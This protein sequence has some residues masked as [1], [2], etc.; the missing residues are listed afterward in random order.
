MWKVALCPR[1]SHDLLV[2]HDTDPS[3][4]AQCPSCNVLFQVCDAISREL[5]EVRLVDPVPGAPV[6]APTPPEPP[7][8][9]GATPRPLG[10]LPFS[11]ELTIGEFA[12]QGDDAS[13]DVTV[14]D[15]SLPVEPPP[16]E[17]FL[18][19][20]RQSKATLPDIDTSSSKTW[21]EL[22]A[23]LGAPPEIEQAQ[24][25]LSLGQP[26]PTDDPEDDLANAQTIAD[27]ATDSAVPPAI[28]NNATIEIGEAFPSEL[29]TDFELE[30]AAAQPPLPTWD[31]S[32]Q[33]E[34]LL[35]GDDDAPTDDQ[36]ELVQPAGLSTAD[37]QEASDQPIVDVEM[38]TMPT[39]LRRRRQPSLVRT[40]VGIVL[41]GVVG[42]GLGYVLLLWLLG[43]SGD[44]LQ[45]AH[46]LPSVVLPES[47][48]GPP[49]QAARSTP[50]IDRDAKP[51][52]FDAPVDDSKSP[53]QS[54]SEPSQFDP[55]AASPIAA[56]ADAPHVT[57]A[58]SYSADE[59][60]AALRAAQEAQPNLVR[61][62]LGDGKAVQQAKGHSYAKLCDLANAATFVGAASQ[63][64][65]VEGVQRE[66]DTLFHD[67]LVDA[68]TRGE[69]ARIAPMWI[70]NKRRTH[71]GVFL[72]G[73]VTDAVAQGDVV[74]CQIDLGAGAPLTLIV[75]KPL[76]E[77]LD[78]SH[79]AIGVVGAIVDSPAQHITGYTGSA[80]QAVWVGRIV[81]LE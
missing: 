67:T 33:M 51:A 29:D 41:S 5:A 74:E 57:N 46:Y 12:T 24:V 26:I 9:E 64:D 40:M 76:A 34:R 30:T 39:G 56:A 47:F 27:I 52:R 59:L 66:V 37:E 44:F 35:N 19:S 14:A 65:T 50:Q 18:D 16:V 8:V 42:L 6:D 28:G 31:D 13:L 55:P 80:T 78:H 53:A 11:S 77:R 63:S 7:R 54:V 43:P 20:L 62:D 61:G 79:R 17:S 73:T 48:A 45:V 75:P 4:W 25:D 60:S 70:S 38:F 15:E 22:P 10:T 58:Q 71:G 49:P 69:V 2:P 36:P 68:H 21:Q 3:A 72:A 23:E 1:C 81:P 32:E